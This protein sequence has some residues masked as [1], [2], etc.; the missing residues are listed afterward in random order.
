MVS[1]SILCKVSNRLLIFLMFSAFIAS[2]FNGIYYCV[3]PSALSVSIC[4]S[5]IGV[6][7]KFCVVYN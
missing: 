6:G 4:V 2:S 7:S 1:C 3:G 5:Y